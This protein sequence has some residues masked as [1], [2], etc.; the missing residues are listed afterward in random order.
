[1][2]KIYKTIAIVGVAATLAACSGRTDTGEDVVFV[3]T[4]TPEPVSTK[5]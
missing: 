1:M 5:Y 3:P 2:Q 4:V